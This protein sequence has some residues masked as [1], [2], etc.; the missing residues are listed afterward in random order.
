MKRLCTQ[1]ENLLNVIL[2]VK[3]KSHKSHIVLLKNYNP[4]LQHFH[5]VFLVLR[6]IREVVTFLSYI[7]EST[8]GY[9]L[10]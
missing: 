5:I 3:K 4:K 7:E 2:K 9:S 6:L 8:V 10:Q 1:I